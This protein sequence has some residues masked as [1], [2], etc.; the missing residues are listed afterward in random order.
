[1]GLR[2][3]L[4]LFLVALLSPPPEVAIQLIAEEFLH[5]FRAVGM[6][7]HHQRGVL[8]QG[9]DDR[10]CALRVRAYHWCPHH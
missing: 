7:H 3:Q 1:M 6:P 4:R 5:R 2:S 8:R 10:S 9:F